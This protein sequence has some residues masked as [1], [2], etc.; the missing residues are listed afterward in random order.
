MSLTD[1]EQ[2]DTHRIA[3]VN[4]AHLGQGWDHHVDLSVLGGYCC[5]EH[6]DMSPEIPQ[7]CML[8]QNKHSPTKY[9]E[10]LEGE[11]IEF[12]H[13]SQLPYLRDAKEGLLCLEIQAGTYSF[14]LA[15]VKLIL[16]DI[17]PSLLFYSAAHQPEPT[18]DHFAGPEYQF[19]TA[20]SL[21]APYRVPQALDLERLKVLVSGRRVSAEDDIF[22]LMEDPSYFIDTY[23]EWSEHNDHR[24]HKICKCRD[25]RSHIAARVLE[26]AF[27][28]FVYW[29]DI[30]RKL[31]AMPELGIQMSRADESRVK[32]A[33]E[34][35]E[36][37][38]ALMGVVWQL[39]WQPMVLLKDGLPNSPRM[40][41]RYEW[42]EEVGHTGDWVWLPPNIWMLRLL[43]S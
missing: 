22:L 26:N 41:N 16:R 2:P 9:G 27:V 31:C 23:R 10:V 7:S 33:E 13:P 11:D 38:A 12:L 17:K 19:L 1:S 36:R 42:A 32:L 29:D 15:C 4:L 39:L 6:F 43:R 18:I 34:D 20:H 5:D 24:P 37:W 8:F 25:C 3:D 30:Y 35:C 14:L 40:R 28:N 21:E